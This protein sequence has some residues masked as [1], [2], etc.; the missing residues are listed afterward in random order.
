M[1]PG[2]SNLV[3]TVDIVLAS[4]LRGW[5]SVCLSAGLKISVVVMR[6]DVLTIKEY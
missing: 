2:L 5:S 6:I 1:K 4:W 3:G